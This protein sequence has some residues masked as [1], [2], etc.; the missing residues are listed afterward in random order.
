MNYV[1]WNELCL[2]YHGFTPSGFKNIKITKFELHNTQY[3]IH[4]IQYTIH[5]TQ[6]TI[7]NTQYTI[8]NTHT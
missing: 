6:Y 5:N 7:H 1:G 4:N 2:K 8:H 3:T